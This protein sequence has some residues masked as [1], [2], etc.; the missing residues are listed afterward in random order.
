VTKF[1]TSLNKIIR[2]YKPLSYYIIG[3]VCLFVFVF[4]FKKYLYHHLSH[5]FLIQS[6]Y[7]FYS[8][9][10]LH[11]YSWLGFNTDNIKHGSILSPDTGPLGNFKI[12]LLLMR[13]SLIFLSLVAFIPLNFFKKVIDAFW[14]FFSLQIFIIIRIAVMAIFIYS[15]DFLAVRVISELSVL[16]MNLGLFL[17]IFYWFKVDF[18]LKKVLIE[19]LKISKELLRSLFLK[20]FY[21]ILILGTVNLLIRTGLFNLNYT[22]TYGIMKVSSLLLKFGGFLSYI[23]HSSLVGKNLISIHLGYPCIGINLMFVFAAFIVFMNG[24]LINKIWFV[25]SGIVLIYLMNILRVTFLFIYL[26]KSGKND[27]L[28]VDVHDIYSYT[29]YFVIFLMWVLWIKKFNFSDNH[30]HS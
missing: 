20:A 23:D 7:H 16:I 3:L 6:Y 2:N 18:A 15:S 29:V 11:I 10:A 28:F 5:F 19:K 25:C 1:F 9:I 22:L 21:C 14:L 27:A 17:L 26:V 30:V 13:Q 12:K 24:R 4:F 8:K